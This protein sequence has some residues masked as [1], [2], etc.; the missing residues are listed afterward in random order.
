MRILPKLLLVF[1]I[2]FDFGIISV[3]M[4]FFATV[5]A[6]IWHSFF[7]EL[8][9]NEL[10]VVLA[11]LA[12][13]EMLSLL[14]LISRLSQ[15]I[16]YFITFQVFSKGFILLIEL[17][18]GISSLAL[19]SLSLKSL[20]EEFRDWFLRQ[21]GCVLCEQRWSMSLMQKKG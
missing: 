5:L 12:S 10:S 4:I 14:L 6:E 15:L 16:F 18:L 20:I 21:L 8:L 2:L 9:F 3:I 11:V 13:V 19:E 7:F 17:F 1:E